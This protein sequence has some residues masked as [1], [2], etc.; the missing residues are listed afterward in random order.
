MLRAA[1]CMFA[2]GSLVTGCAH[3]PK[4]AEARASLVQD[5]QAAVEQMT[6]DDPS[7]RPLLDQSA[8]YVVFPNIKQGGFIAGGAA[9]RGVVFEQGR[10]TGFAEL[11]EASFGAQVG[12]QKFAE[13]I[14]V[15][16]P[17]ALAQLK[18]GEY[19]IGAQAQATAIRS[20]SGAATLFRDGV[21]VFVRP[22]SGGMLN[23]S[24]TGQ[25]I[26]FKG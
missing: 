17:Y 7:L 20:G 9:G 23:L 26:K 3:A 13:L 22:L 8:G 12:G 21:A 16:D 4:T 25:R 6:M 15:R 24:V 19:H 10:A 1:A 5:A 11:S 18:A 2:L 14:V